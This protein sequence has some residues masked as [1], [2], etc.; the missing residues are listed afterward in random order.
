MN[1]FS[2]GRKIENSL[3]NR[4]LVLCNR[5]ILSK[6]SSKLKIASVSQTFF[7]EQLETRK[8]KMRKRFLHRKK[9]ENSFSFAYQDSGVFFSGAHRIIPPGE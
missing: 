3:N 5:W 4:D 2:N 6:L 8:I 9:E 1:N 7:L